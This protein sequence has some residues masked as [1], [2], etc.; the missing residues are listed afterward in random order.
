VTR[1]VLVDLDLEKPKKAGRV[2][3]N[4]N[5]NILQTLKELL[6]EALVSFLYTETITA[7]FHRVG[8]SGAISLS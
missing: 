1:F 7:W 2:V 3:T 6:T 5:P 8:K 4:Y